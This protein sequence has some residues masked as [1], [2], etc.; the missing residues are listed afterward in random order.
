MARFLQTSELPVREGV[1]EVPM[2]CLCWR[3]TLR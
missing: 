2:R 1:I 3:T